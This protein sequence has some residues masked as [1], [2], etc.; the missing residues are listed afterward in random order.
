M[1][2]EPN[3]A[4]FQ[5]IVKR[6]QENPSLY[7]SF[8]TAKK[9]GWLPGRVAKGPVQI[10]YCNDFRGFSPNV[11]AVFCLDVMPDMVKQAIRALSD[12]TVVMY[13]QTGSAFKSW[14]EGIKVKLEAKQ[15]EQR[16][17]AAQA[18]LQQSRGDVVAVAAQAET[19]KV[20]NGSSVPAHQPTATRPLELMSQWPSEVTA[21][22]PLTPTSKEDEMT[23]PTPAEAAQASTPPNT[24]RRANRGELQDIFAELGFSTG[25]RVTTVR[26]RTREYQKAHGMVVSVTKVIDTNFEKYKLGLTATSSTPPT[27]PVKKSQGEEDQDNGEFLFLHDKLRLLNKA[28]LEIVELIVDGLLAKRKLEDFKRQ[29]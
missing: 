23:Q 9:L 20:G 19:L 1:V 3:D 8:V 15:V 18:K 12:D 24:P 25:T 5:D 28:E 26:K 27:P 29:L 11:I 14:Y 10:C 22:K 17:L 6:L 13:L 16:A 4:V 7:I 21:G 2:V